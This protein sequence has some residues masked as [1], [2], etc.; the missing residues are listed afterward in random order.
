MEKIF[1]HFFS[2][3]NEESPDCT[4]TGKVFLFLKW[5]SKLTEEDLVEENVPSGSKNYILH[6]LSNIKAKYTT[7]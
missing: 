5:Q 7:H 1:E 4:S 6:Y 2:L 3:N